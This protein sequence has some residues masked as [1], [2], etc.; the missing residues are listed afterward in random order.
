M[1]AKI[2]G[3]IVE[4]SPSSVIIMSSGVGFEIF[5]S[6][7]TFEKLPD[8]G[9]EAELNIY[10]Y[11]RE[12][13]ISLVGFDSLEEKKVFLQ[14]LDVSGV[15]IRIAL[16]IFSLYSVNEVKNIIAN[17]EVEL[18]KRVSGIGKKLAD[19]IILELCEKF[20]AYR[21]LVIS[22]EIFKDKK[23]VE[24]RQ[25]LNSLGY[26][27]QEINKALKSLDINYIK[28]NKIEDIL[29]KALKEV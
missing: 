16:S 4:K 8:I 9:S 15:S 2:K 17:R 13:S 7:R 25:A 18:L 11:L 28:S 21:D 23:I 10:T 14:L 5:V 1:I 3:K 26:S 27:N 20:S 19:R 6:S 22:G 24:V 29:K 12:D